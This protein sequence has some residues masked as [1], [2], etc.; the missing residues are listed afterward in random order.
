MKKILLT[1]LTLGGL[2]FASSCQMDEPDA[3]KLTGEVDFSI[4]AG[5]PGSINTYASNDGGATNVLDD[6]YDQRFIL[7]V[8]D[9][10]ALAY[11]EEKT[12]E[13]GNT[14][15]FD[16]RLL[17]KK[18]KMALWADFV[19]NERTDDN[20]YSTENGLDEVTVKSGR[21]A[22]QEIADA[23]CHSE[24]IDLTEGSLSK[25]IT[26]TRPFGK[27]RL[28]STDNP[29]NVGATAPASV[30]VTYGSTIEVPSGYNVLTD[31]ASST[32]ISAGTYSF[33]P[34]KEAVS[35]G[36]V[37]K[38][39]LYILGIDYIFA[40][41]SVTNVSF[42]VKVDG[43]GT[44]R[45]GNIPVSANKLTTVI[46]NFYTN[47]GS[48][49]VIVEDEF[50][51]PEI[52]KDENTEIIMTGPD[53]NVAEIVRNMEEP[54]RLV[55]VGSMTKEDLM[56]IQSKFISA[57][58][59][60]PHVMRE[61]DL[62]HVTG[63]TD[64]PN[65]AFSA[66]SNSTYYSNE[67]L[68]RIILPEGVRSIGSCAFSCLKAMKEVNIPESVRSI[69]WS[70]FYG[71]SSLESVRIPEGVTEIPELC[72][73]KCSSLADLYIPNSVKKIGK[74]NVFYDTAITEVNLGEELEEIGEYAFYFCR[75]LEKITFNSPK[76][77]KLSGNVFG[78][79]NLTELVLPEN[80]EEL[81]KWALSGVSIKKIV[82]PATLKKM[83]STSIPRFAEL[84]VTVYAPVPPEVLEGG[85]LNPSVNS[86]LRVPAA[87]V[88]AYKDAPAWNKFT[89]IVAI[90]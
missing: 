86:T 49:E 3:G 6:T 45:V 75:K 67:V 61:L 62:S 47:E 42:D 14:A 19:E 87:S 90:E 8:Y 20:L 76:L 80:L 15:S 48:L 74:N 85:V 38:G 82:M 84:D 65:Y 41:R 1:F 12:V 68:E 83:Y 52:V 44:R 51:H 9:G 30:Q 32:K 63:L 10:D 72:F 22:G 50:K 89:N 58:A 36:G 70:A 27:I 59:P 25:P 55:V 4:T 64:I 71:C 16:V 39:E 33:V 7:E 60:G 77:K 23:Y 54:E 21:S 73:F 46:G 24:E 40:S 78:Q 88:Q 31:E 37:S 53:V 35:V 29:S 2:L 69:G 56:A 26:L 79:T 11:R 18:Y 66:S 28:V 13:I 34:Y 43:N 17:A 57:F 5:V 81:D